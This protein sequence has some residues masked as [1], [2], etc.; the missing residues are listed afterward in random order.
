VLVTLVA[1]RRALPHWIAGLSI[2]ICGIGLVAL[3]SRLIPGSFSSR[4]LDVFL[5]AAAT[6][7]SFP[8]GYWNGLAI[9]LALGVPLLLSIA[10]ASQAPAIRGL[11]LA[12]IPMIA[13]VIYLASSRG[14]VVTA[15]VGGATFLALTE[16]RWAATAAIVT[17]ALGG[18]VT[19]ALLLQRHELVDGPLGTHLVERQGRSAA[20]LI[21]LACA[22]TGV[23]YAIGC[24][25]LLGRKIRPAP[26]VG[27]AI[28]GVV[29][30]AMAIAVAAANPAQRF[31]TFKA[32]PGQLAAI[33]RGNFVQQH[34]VSSRGSGRWQFWSAAVE[35]WRS[36]PI[37]GRGAGSYGSWWAEHGSI[38][39]FVTNAHSLYLETLGELGL[40]GLALIVAVVGLGSYVGVTR[41]LRA[42]GAVRVYAAALTGVFLGCATAAG[43]DWIWEL[44]SVSLVGFTALALV[45]GPAT[46]TPAGV[47]AV[48]ADR[49][50]RRARRRFGLGVA[51]ILIA[52]SLVCAQAIPLLAQREITRSQD[53]AARGDLAQALKAAESAR[54]IQPWA[55][56]PYLQ[57]ALV[58]EQV[59]ALQPARN[60]IDGAI[61]RDRND[62]RL[63]L[64]SARIETKLGLVNAAAVSLRRAIELN[65]RSP[66]FAG[67]RTSQG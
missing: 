24:K 51:A 17:S 65:P 58:S 20:G 7:L 57:L 31:Q 27:W 60:W 52:W 3:T 48:D 46:A 53:A 36:A 61:A 1:R 9:F 33:D 22:A 43:F 5:P 66:L 44:T 49:P 13:C 26:V 64:V 21:A 28:V 4:D 32:P 30:I 29:V 38:P 55:A 45:T 10:V 59:G 54:D 47:S 25:V 6:R 16:R 63:W 8:L 34:L 23:L 40:I 18:A 39:L 2:A 56:T 14:G 19:I 67:M 15:V 62:W 50:A 41:A 35:Q 37:N 11:A 12:P 42:S